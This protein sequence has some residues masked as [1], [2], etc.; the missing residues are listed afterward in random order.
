MQLKVWLIVLLSALLLLFLLT[1]LSSKSCVTPT[2]EV[3]VK[4]F[5]AAGVRR[6]VSGR[7]QAVAAEG[8][9]P[10]AASVAMA[11]LEAAAPS[12]RPQRLNKGTQYV[13]DIVFEDEA[14]LLE[15][16]RGLD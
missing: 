7:R 10:G 12:V 14:L 13:V 1:L 8:V 16:Q 5:A 6:A 11:K 2:L 9:F 15:G 4:I 3:F